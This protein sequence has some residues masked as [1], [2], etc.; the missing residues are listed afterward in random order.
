MRLSHSERLLTQSLGDLKKKWQQTESV[1]KDRARANF[2]K[3]FLEELEPAVK[4]AVNSM[5]E[6]NKVLMQV[7]KECGSE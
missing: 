4:S 7:I 5:N 6:I 1:W 3:D 2:E